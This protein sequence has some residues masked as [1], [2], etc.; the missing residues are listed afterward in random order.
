MS[1]L[2]RAIQIAVEA[3]AGQRGK[4]GEPYI[5]HPLRVML[6]QDD[7]AA[8]IV[9][10]LHDVVEHSEW[11]LEDLTSEGFPLQV[12]EAVDAMTRRDGEEYSQS[13]LR[14]RSN[15][16]ARYVKIADLRD[17]LDTVIS[18]GDSERKAMYEQALALMAGL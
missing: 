18:T 9:G 4:D 7:Y 15:P 12:I 11:T 14:A 13:V 5:L 3:H 6:A 2:D 8:R 17:N 10:V 16:V 1:T